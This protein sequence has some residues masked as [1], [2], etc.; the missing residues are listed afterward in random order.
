MPDN[1]T[2]DQLAEIINTEITRQ[3]EVHAS[4]I[5]AL[6]ETELADAILAAGFRPPARVIDTPGELDALQPAQALI[7]DCRAGDNTSA[8][9]IQ[10]AHRHVYTRDVDNL[11]AEADGG[12]RSGWWKTGTDREFDSGDLAYPITVLWTPEETDRAR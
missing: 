11:E 1:E 4:Y 8:A 2:R 12:W 6:Y 9:I 5:S 3:V 7:D 10:D